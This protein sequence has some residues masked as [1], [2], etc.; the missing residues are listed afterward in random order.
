LVEEERGGGST[1]LPKPA[2]LPPCDGGR[3]LKHER[4]QKLIKNSTRT[5]QGT[6]QQSAETKAKFI[7]KLAPLSFSRWKILTLEKIKRGL[8]I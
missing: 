2:Y 8:V 6:L 7:M 1:V 4:K 5:R 3:S